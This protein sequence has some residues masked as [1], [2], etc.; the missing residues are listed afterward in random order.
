MTRPSPAACSSRWPSPTP[1][2]GALVTYNPNDKLDIEAGVVNGWDEIATDN[3]GKTLNLHAGYN[4]GDPLSLSLTVLYGTAPI[5]GFEHDKRLSVDLTGLTKVVKNLALNFQ[6]NYGRQQHAA[7]LTTKAGEGA[8]WFGAGVQPVYTIN[9]K[10][11]IGG[12]LEWLTDNDDALTGPATSKRRLITVSVAPAY[13]VTA[14]FLARVEA[15]YDSSNQEDFTNKSGTPKKNQ[16][17][18][19]AESIFSF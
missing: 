6:L 14:H 5:V 4:W 10:W 18:L 11:S 17:E 2:T 12:R 3:Q 7:L 19:A 1:T 13:Q 9:D 8:S 15:R 16:G